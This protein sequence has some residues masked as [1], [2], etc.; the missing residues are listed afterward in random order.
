MHYS[1]STLSGISRNWTKHCVDPLSVK[2]ESNVKRK[3][4]IFGLYHFD[5]CFPYSMGCIDTSHP[6]C[7]RYFPAPNC[8]CNDLSSRFHR[9]PQGRLTMH[10]HKKKTRKTIF[11]KDQVFLTLACHHVVSKAVA[12]WTIAHWTTLCLVAA[13][14]ALQITAV[15]HI[16]KASK[17]KM[18]QLGCFLVI[19]SVW[20]LEPQ[21]AASQCQVVKT[22]V[23]V[24]WGVLLM[25]HQNFCIYLGLNLQSGLIG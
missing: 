2:Q 15:S 10:T 7:C 21:F 1:L 18:H 20:Q 3:L 11:S 25:P 9:A 6:L 14:T 19:I 13:M 4:A 5:I 22:K 12:S 8:S 23:V 17:N 16:C 24:E